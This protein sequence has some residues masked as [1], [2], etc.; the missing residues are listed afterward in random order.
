MKSRLVIFAI[1]SS[2]ATA[3]SEQP[4]PPAPVDPLL[5]TWKSNCIEGQLRTFTAPV[6]FGITE[7]SEMTF[8]NEKVVEV[9]RVTSSSCEGNDVEITASGTYKK[10]GFSNPNVLP[11]DVRFDSYKVKPVTEFGV[12]VMNPGKWCG[13]DDWTLGVERDVT[14]QIGKENCFPASTHFTVHAVEGESLYFGERENATSSSKRP[15]D[16]KKDL[17]YTRLPNKS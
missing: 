15:Q 9:S 17:T 6:R 4:S 1:V 7:H 11:I 12:K 2:I 10:E 5:G 14:N 16:L 13:I 3:C 8:E